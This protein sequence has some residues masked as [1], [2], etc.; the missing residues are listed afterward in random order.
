MPSYDTV[1][2]LLGNNIELSDT[3]DYETRLLPQDN[4]QLQKDLKTSIESPTASVASQKVLEKAEPASQQPGVSREQSPVKTPSPAE[5]EKLPASAIDNSS[6]HLSTGHT[7]STIDEFSELL[8]A[9]PL[10]I[11]D[12]ST[13]IKNNFKPNE[14]FNIKSAEA[15]RSSLTIKVKH[16]KNAIKIRERILESIGE[17]HSRNVKIWENFDPVHVDVMFDAWKALQNHLSSS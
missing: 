10:K 1:L 9:N 8:S 2:P 7:P 5:N 15:G 11:F 12:V 13:L 6:K 17:K 4:R 16:E 3:K 14:D